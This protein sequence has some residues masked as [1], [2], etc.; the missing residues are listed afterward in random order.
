MEIHRQPTTITIVQMQLS[1]VLSLLGVTEHDIESANQE[2][3]NSS[4]TPLNVDK[5]TTNQSLWSTVAA[6]K[7]QK[8]PNSIQ[9]SL[10]AAVCS[11]LSESRRRESSLIITGLSKDQQ[12]FHTEQFQ[13]VCRDEFN[14]LPAIL[15]TRRLGP[16]QPNKSRLLVIVTRTLDQTQQLIA[17]AKQL[18]HSVKQSVRDN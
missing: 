11:D 8:S 6:K 3:D 9:Q 16:V 17:A 13:H 4:G 2:A 15:S 12:Y 14:V 1:F 18:C 7:T 5:H 10:I